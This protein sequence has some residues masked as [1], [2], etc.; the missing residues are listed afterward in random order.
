M[1][2]L[3]VGRFFR[4]LFVTVLLY[5]S[6]SLHPIDALRLRRSKKVHLGRRSKKAHRQRQKHNISHN[7]NEKVNEQAD[8]DETDAEIAEAELENQ[9]DLVAEDA[10]DVSMDD[11]VVDTKEE[12]E[13]EL[14]TE[15]SGEDTGADENDVSDSDE[16]DVDEDRTLDER[17]KMDSEH[18]DA[19]ATG[20]EDHV[21]GDH[22][23]L[24][25]ED[26]IHDEVK[27]ESSST[28]PVI[29]KAKS[30]KEDQSTTSKDT[31]TS[32]DIQSPIVVRKAGDRIDD[33]VDS[34]TNAPS[35]T[36]SSTIEGSSAETANNTVAG[37]FVHPENG[38]T[39][40]GPEVAA[41]PP[42]SV[43]VASTP[44]IQTSLEE[45]QE[46]PASATISDTWQFLRHSATKVGFVA[47]TFLE[48]QSQ[49]E[50]VQRDFEADSET[51]KAL[52]N[53]YSAK[54]RELRS[55]VARERRLKR[56]LESA[57]S[58]Y[59]RST[60][61]MSELKQLISEIT[62]DM[63]KTTTSRKSA[64]MMMAS[65]VKNLNERIAATEY[66]I[67][68]KEEERMA[69]INGKGR[70]TMMMTNQNIADSK[71]I[72]ADS[73]I[74]SKTVVLDQ[75]Q[76]E[77]EEENV[78]EEILRELEDKI[79]KKEKEVRNLKNHAYVKADNMISEIR[80][81][82]LKLHRL[83]MLKLQAG[84]LGE[85][86]KN[87]VELIKKNRANLEA[88]IKSK[89]EEMEQCTLKKSQVQHDIEE[90]QRKMEKIEENR[91]D[92]IKMAELTDNMKKSL[93]LNCKEGNSDDE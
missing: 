58:N 38:A 28:D 37:D 61:R 56:D 92:C 50:S 86:Y 68:Q 12:S 77:M 11:G 48:L 23:E 87:K 54:N 93:I 60:K 30:N 7:E 52:E 18:E 79:G 4:T 26:H 73:L 64:K 20:H 88:L 78:S 57:K 62:L 22:E 82:Q 31:H 17:Q 74:K 32:R 15:E 85:E 40:T 91:Q 34:T 44:R 13:S 69:A 1:V 2:T 27:P 8:V 53:E 90:I 24:M 83:K 51:H 47:Q 6:E 80:S 9:D 70:K 84:K 29:L 3:V 67:Q 66:F 76:S 46:T 49:L 71:S 63:A 75:M 19:H 81:L 65:K 42:A 16:H 89:K 35:T 14:D 59:E 43:P 33:P 21:D 72:K 25:T 55:S 36:Q 45:P 5:Y 10:E 41:T 39:N